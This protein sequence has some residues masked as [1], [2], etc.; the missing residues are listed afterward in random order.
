MRALRPAAARRADQPSRPRRRALAR[1]VAAALSRARSCS[2]RTT[3]ISSTRSSTPSCISTGRK[4]RSTAATIR[5]SRRQRAQA[6]AQQQAALR[7]A[8]APD[9]APALVHRPLS[10]QGDQGQAG[11]EPDQDAGAHGADRGG[12]RR[13]PVLVRVSHRPR[14]HAPARR[15]SSTPTL[16]YAGKPVLRAVDW[17]ILAGERIGLLG[18]ERRGQVH[19]CCA[20]L[21]ASLRRSPGERLTAQ[22]SAHRLLRAAPG[23][24]TAS[25]RNRA[26]APATAGAGDARAGAARFPRRLRLSRRSRVEHRPASSPAARRRGSPWRCSCGSGRTCSCST[27]RPT[28]STS[29]CAKR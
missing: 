7:Q 3:A 26:V 27:S 18:T 8:A 20:R 17:A 15:S 4:L 14:P 24:A 25:E 21:R 22:E 12:A 23:R 28:I 13:Q 2:S 9:R 29:R 6:L 5:S 1:G 11:A 16:G 10:R 19:A